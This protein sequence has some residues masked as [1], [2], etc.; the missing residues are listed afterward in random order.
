MKKIKILFFVLLAGAL[1]SCSGF[2]RDAKEGSDFD[3]KEYGILVFSATFLKNNYQELPMY[4]TLVGEQGGSREIRMDMEDDNLYVLIVKEGYYRIKN[5]YG[6]NNSPAVTRAGSSKETRDIYAEYEWGTSVKAGYLNY[7]GNFMMKDFSDQKD[8]YPVLFTI[9]QEVYNMSADIA[10]RKRMTD[11][12]NVME[13]YPYLKSYQL[14]VRISIMEQEMGETG[15]SSQYLQSKKNNQK[16][17][18]YG[19]YTWGA[20]VEEIKDMLSAENKKILV[21]DKNTLID[22]TNAASIIEF[23]FVENGKDSLLGKIMIHLN[24]NLYDKTFASIIE[25]YGQFAK[26]EGETTIWFTPYSKISLSKTEKES[27]LVYEAVHLE[28]NNDNKMEDII[29]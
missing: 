5:V 14:P 4:F 20:P 16:I 3:K 17:K 7:V 15:K 28:V 25:K 9:K 13:K 23:N 19:N 8:K 11:L 1:V 27:L 2:I 12:P 26:K 21:I 10:M 18:G 24:V 6:E 29:K 22:N